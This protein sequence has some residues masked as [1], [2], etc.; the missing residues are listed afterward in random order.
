MCLLNERK[1]LARALV[2]AF[3][4]RMQRRT[5]SVCLPAHQGHSQREPL[6][7]AATQIISQNTSKN[8]QNIFKKNFFHVIL[9]MLEMNPGVP[10]KPLASIVQNAPPP[11]TSH[12][13]RGAHKGGSR[14]AKPGPAS[15]GF[16]STHHRQHT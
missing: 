3:S 7:E 8:T 16:T 1:Q 10:R 11:P 5:L 6:H 15:P 13:V 12:R 4:F 9:D 14:H 2:A